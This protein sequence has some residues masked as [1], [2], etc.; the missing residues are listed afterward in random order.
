MVELVADKYSLCLIIIIHF[1]LFKYCTKK[2]FIEM[3]NTKVPI[4]LLKIEQINKS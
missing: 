1:L 4:I 2:G 3:V